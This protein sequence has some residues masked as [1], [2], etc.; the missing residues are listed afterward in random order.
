VLPLVSPLDGLADTRS[1]PAHM[2]QHLF[3]GDVGPALV[4]LAVRGPLLAFVIPVAAARFLGRRARFLGVLGNPVVA[5]SVWIVAVAGWHVPTAYDAAVASPRLH[6]LEHASFVFAGFLVWWQLVDSARRARLSVGARAALA[7]VV[8]FAGQALCDFLLFSPTR[9]YN[10]YSLSGQQYAA[11]VM[12]A[13]QF[14]TLGT[15]VALLG[16]SLLRQGEPRRRERALVGQDD[17]RLVRT[18]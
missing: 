7:G 10:A 16:L 13:E 14:L 2:L 3:I 1:L 8:F 18:A 6:D 4:L 11:I 12:G 5:L 15:C 9:L 17:E